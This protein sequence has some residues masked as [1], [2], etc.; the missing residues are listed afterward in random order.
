MYAAKYL[1][2]ERNHLFV[3]L[4]PLARV[5]WSGDAC[6]RVNGVRAQAMKGSMYGAARQRVLDQQNKKMIAFM[7]QPVGQGVVVES[8]DRQ[9]ESRDM[10][11]GGAKK[12]AKD[13]KAP[14]KMPWEV[15]RGVPSRRL[16][17][18]A[19]VSAC[20]LT[21]LAWGGFQEPD[22]PPFDPVQE[23]RQLYLRI[24]PAGLKKCMF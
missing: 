10:S 8:G 3:L 2:A 9:R 23:K 6:G 4:H 12:G 17:L 1:H 16:S 18:A 11:K 19:R 14:R 5:L 20:A 15:R 24:Q 21:G 13:K 22:E 7:H